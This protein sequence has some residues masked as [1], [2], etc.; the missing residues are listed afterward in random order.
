MAVLR[1]ERLKTV[2][3]QSLEGCLLETAQHVLHV[4]EVFLE[5]QS[6]LEA[7]AI[8]S[9]LPHGFVGLK[10][11]DSIEKNGGIVKDIAGLFNLAG[12]EQTLRV[13]L[14]QTFVVSGGSVQWIDVARMRKRGIKASKGATASGQHTG[15]WKERLQAT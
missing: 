8:G 13:E 11:E 5:V 6:V 4:C 7:M 9:L 12:I 10:G 1:L 14:N 3:D 15:S 2:V